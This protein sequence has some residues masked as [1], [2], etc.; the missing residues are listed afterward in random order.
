[1]LQEVLQARQLPVP[2]YEIVGEDG[3][4]HFRIFEV[5]LTV[6]DLCSATGRGATRRKAEQVAAAQALDA[7]DLLPE[8]DPEPSR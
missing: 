8:Q 4:P 5:R 6:G 3:P 2:Q 1:V 7:M